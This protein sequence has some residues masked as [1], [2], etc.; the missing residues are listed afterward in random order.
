LQGPR[1]WLRSS[2]DGA[3]IAFLMRDDD[4]VVQ[5]WKVSP[6]GGEPV[7]VTRYSFD[8]ASAFSWSPDGKSLAYVADGSIFVTDVAAGSSRR[9]TPR[10]DAALAPRPEACVF[11]PAGRQIAYVRPVEQNGQL[12]NQVFV[13]TLPGGPS[14]AR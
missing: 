3:Q 12:W 5:L 7:L 1:H 13:V 10:R 4:G 14:P 8:I 2:P 9:L 11:S 6:L